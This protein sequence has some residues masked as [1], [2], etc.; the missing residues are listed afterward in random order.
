VEPNIVRLDDGRLWMLIRTKNGFLYESFSTN[1]GALWSEP[2]PTRFISSDSPACIIRLEDGRQVLFLNSCQRYDDPRSYAVG[3]R[4]VLHAAIRTR[5]E[6]SWFGFREV[7]RD[8]PADEDSES[9]AGME[10]KRRP[11]TQ[12]GGA[13]LGE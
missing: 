10:F 1:D 8:L 6:G 5:K 3:G 7:L 2:Q 12:T 9:A 13:V 11:G 4:E